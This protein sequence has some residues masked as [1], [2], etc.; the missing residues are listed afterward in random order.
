LGSALQCFGGC[1]QR[2]SVTHPPSLAHPDVYAQV[3]NV[4]ESEAFDRWE[5]SKPSHY[6]E[7]RLSR[8]G[9]TPSKAERKAPGGSGGG[10]AAKGK[11]RGAAKGKARG[12]ARSTSAAGTPRATGSGSAKK[13]GAAA[14]LTAGPCWVGS[15]PLLACGGT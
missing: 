9:S 4:E 14:S 3:E 15:D 2:L 5:R 8:G 13:N 6:Q 11:A 12:A 10:G 1:P 7:R